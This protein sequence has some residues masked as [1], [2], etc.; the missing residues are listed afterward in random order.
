MWHSPNMRPSYTSCT[1]GNF[2]LISRT[3]S[4]CTRI[5]PVLRATLF[6]YLT[7]SVDAFFVGEKQAPISKPHN[8]CLMTSNILLWWPSWISNYTKERWLA[9][10]SSSQIWSHFIL[11][12]WGEEDGIRIVY[13]WRMQNNGNIACTHFPSVQ[14]CY[15]LVHIS[16]LYQST[17]NTQNLSLQNKY[18]F[19]V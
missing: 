19:S 15:K 6:W 11:R 10:K 3:I 17:C 12:N 18:L 2:I 4:G 14:V 5:Y 1:Q 16:H 13:R 8:I 9:I 7:Q